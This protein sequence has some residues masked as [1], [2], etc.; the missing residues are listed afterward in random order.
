M[1]RGVTDRLPVY[2]CFDVGVSTFGH[3]VSEYIGELE[4]SSTNHRTPLPPPQSTHP[5]FPPY[6][7]VI[8]S[9]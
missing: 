3:G 8:Y 6:L 4:F 9:H 1:Q 5:P 7:P 2:I